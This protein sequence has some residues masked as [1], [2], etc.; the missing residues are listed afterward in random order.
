MNNGL[1]IGVADRRLAPYIDHYWLGTHNTHSH[2]AI[3]PDGCVDLVLH[4]G[5]SQVQ[6]WLFGT[7]TRR[8]DLPLAIGH[9]YLGIRFR[10]A[11]SRHFIACP[12]HCLTDQQLDAEQLLRLTLAP[13]AEQLHR[14]VR[15]EQLWRGLDRVLLDFLAKH[16]PGPDRLDPFIERC[17]R[18]YDQKFYSFMHELELS[19][20]QFQRLFSQQ[21]GISPKRFAMIMR[22]QT[23]LALLHS[24]P[25]AQLASL[26]AAMGFADQSHMSREIK[27]FSGHTPQAV[28]RQALR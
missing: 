4:A 18:L 9:H 27:R 3:L 17:S 15:T 8:I 13:S 6:T 11:Q 10:P 21:V 5:P 25:S 23:T 19:P 22:C 14:P 28:Q 24:T 2:Y 26:A 1:Q 20:R 12:A 7:A 16:P